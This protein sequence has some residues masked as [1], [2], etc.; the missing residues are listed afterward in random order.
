MK[1]ALL[2][3]SGVV[4]LGAPAADASA[5]VRRFLLVAGANRGSADRPALQYAVTDA[6]RF[7]RVLGELGG[8]GP[9]HTIVLRQPKVGELEQAIDALRSRVLAASREEQGG[10]R[11]E[12]VFYYSGHADEKGLLLAE[13]RYSYRSLRDRLDDV[14]ADVRIAVL[15]ACA[16]GAIT[17]LK[18][19]QLRQPFLV[20]ESAEMRGHAFLTSSTESEAAQE[21][22]RLRGSYFTHFLVSGLRGAADLS[23]EGKVTLNEAYQFAF[24]ETLGRTVDTKGGP[25]HPSYDI[26][27][28][29]TGE[30]VM[31]D[32][33]QTSA[34]LV[35]GKA[36]A[37]R[38][39]VRNAEREVVVEL[40]KPFGREV[41]LG[42][43]AG[44]Y[45]VRLE[46]E[47]ASLL[48]RPKVAE[49]GRVVLEPDQ[50]GITVP[51]PARARGG[52]G[53]PPPLP[54]SVSRRNRFDLRLGMWRLDGTSG[55]VVQTGGEVN[56]LAGLQ[57]TRFL[58]E[59]L[60]VTLGFNSIAES[61]GT[62]LGPEGAFSGGASVVA[63]PLGVRYNPLR[64]DLATQPVKPYLVGSLGPVLGSQGGS[65]A[66][67][68]GSFSGGREEV[69]V[70]GFLGGGVDFH[71]GRN[72]SFGL[73][74]GY[75][76]M[77]DFENPVAARKNYGGFELGVSFGWVFG[78]GSAPRP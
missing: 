27:L 68:T 62:L 44:S 42:L 10:G 9:G 13:D 58:Q 19:G 25:Q 7:A 50:F 76:W 18:G 36:L 43:E 24:N 40:Y 48:A 29:G 14:P 17:R 37:G 4:V 33:R 67:P 72:F 53:G 55:A 69:T 77:A 66:G 32:L 30:V 49:G 26:N 15:D 2:V 38:F 60:A 70:G 28:S 6:E 73:T 23:G 41:E 3:L 47:S 65:F 71:L 61:G 63:I 51:E 57:Y 20:D 74:T 54:L 5:A 31:T 1:S 35:L 56:M 46:Q 45:E 11:T 64:G 39:F 12:V 21:S 16:S 22:D 75:N 78:K 52:P 34:T 59:N 8:V